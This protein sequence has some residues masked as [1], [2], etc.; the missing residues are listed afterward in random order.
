[1]HSIRRVLAGVLLAGLASGCGG[2]DPAGPVAVFG[3]PGTVLLV[4]GSNSVQLS[5]GASSF[6]PSS[7]FSGYNVYLDVVP[8]ST[9]DDPGFLA[10]RAV[11]STP[12]RAT[13]YTVTATPIGGALLQGTKYYM[14]VRTLRSDGSL[15]TASNEVD[16]SP[17]PEGNNGTDPAVSM[18]DYD[19]M[20]NTKSGYGWNVVTGQGVP[21][22]ALPANADGI[23]VLMAE[24]P[25][26]PDEGSLWLSPSV[27]SFSA[28]W[29]TRRTTLFKDLGVGDVAWQTSIAPSPATMSTTVKIQVDHT[30]AVLTQDQH[31]VKVRVLEL[32]KNAVVPRTGGGNVNLNYARFRFAVQLVADYGR[33]KPAP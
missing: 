31:W 10:Q 33:F 19:S 30:Y 23:D 18:Y 25:N 24:E 9:N 2:D 6:E 14:H 17:R 3:P 5:W 29:P 28:G 26:S 4:S 7:E 32:V 15:S 27:A 20:T 13:N 16:T 1:M 22:S 21:Y 12:I 11:N 8:F